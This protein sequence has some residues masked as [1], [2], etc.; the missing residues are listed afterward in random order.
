MTS[1]ESHNLWEIDTIDKILLYSAFEGT[2]NFNK[3]N[4]YFQLASFSLHTSVK[5][6]TD[7]INALLDETKTFLFSL[8]K[9]E[10]KIGYQK[11]NEKEFLRTKNSRKI[12]VTERLISNFNFNS[13]WFGCFSSGI[14]NFFKKKLVFKN[15]LRKKKKC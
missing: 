13:K 9:V 3:S 7:R 6:Y 1:K 15:F 5:V 8:K 12:F 4:Y 14:N 2:E 11:I 10:N